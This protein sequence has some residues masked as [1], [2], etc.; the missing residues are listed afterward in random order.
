MS[1]LKPY[2]HTQCSYLH[3]IEALHSYA[4]KCTSVRRQRVAARRPAARESVSSA[5]SCS[6]ALLETQCYTAQHLT[7]L[8]H[9]EHTHRGSHRA[10][11]RCSTCRRR[12]PSQPCPHWPCR[13]VTGLGLL[14]CG[15]PDRFRWEWIIININSIF[16]C[17]LSDQPLLLRK[18]RNKSYI[19]TSAGMLA[20]VRSV[21]VRKLYIARLANPGDS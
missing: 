16:L 7:A 19:I 3:Y 14:E 13:A 4:G 2:R 17:D 18:L 10:P 11:S 9:L 20:T 21:S 12:G 1:T 8:L 6:S 5:V 15:G